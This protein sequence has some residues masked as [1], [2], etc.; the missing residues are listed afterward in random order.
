MV[1]DVTIFFRYCPFL[2]YIGFGDEPEDFLH[3]RIER[4]NRITRQLLQ[5][6]RLK[7]K[8]HADDRPSVLAASKENSPKEVCDSCEGRDRES[9]QLE[10]W[11]NVANSQDRVV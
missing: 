2:M 7:R 1:F 5:F 4:L 3:D 11:M 10:Y 8:S 6:R 9:R